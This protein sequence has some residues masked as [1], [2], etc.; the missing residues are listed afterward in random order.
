MSL[1]QV[2]ISELKF[3]DKNA[4]K[5]TEQGKRLLDKSITTLGLGRSILIDKDMNIIAGNGVTESAGENGLEDVIVVPTDGTKIIAVQRTD[6]SINSKKGRRLAIADNQTAKVGIE[7]DNPVID[8]LNNE[9]DLDLMAE[10]EMIPASFKDVPSFD[11]ID[12]SSLLTND[13]KADDIDNDE[14]NA[15][16]KLHFTH[17]VYKTITEKLKLTNLAPETIF[18]EAMGL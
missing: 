9:Y 4:N 2:K 14:A 1:K 6:V 10:W 11:N 7:F 17:D 16:L 3:D 8:D 5:H 12:Y 13:N 18:L 15:V